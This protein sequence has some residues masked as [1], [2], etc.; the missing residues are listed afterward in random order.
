[1]IYMKTRNFIRRFILTFIFIFS[2]LG[3]FVTTVQGEMKQISSGVFRFHVLANSDSDYDQALKLKVRNSVIDYV[4]SICAGANLEQTKA[5][6]IENLENIEDVANRVI[7]DEGYNYE[8]RAYVG[9]FDFPTK[10]YGDIA[11]PAGVYS[12]LR[13]EIGEG[14]GANWWCV[15]YPSICLTKTGAYLDDNAKEALKENLSIEEYNLIT[16]KPALK[17]RVLEWLYN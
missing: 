15:I 10:V 4:N 6:C 9:E 8:A 17:F 3:L 14:A 7:K 12:A 5:I 16:E 11:L 13:L 2:L 1:M